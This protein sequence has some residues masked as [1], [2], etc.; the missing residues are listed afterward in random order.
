LADEKPLNGF[1]DKMG[2]NI[3]ALDDAIQDAGPPVE[4][5]KAA[6]KRARVKL[7]RDLVELQNASLATVKSHLLGLH[8]SGASKEPADV[9]ASNPEVMFERDFARCLRPWVESDLKLRCEDCK[10]ERED[11]ESRSLTVKVPSQFPGFPPD[12]ER[13]E[14]HDLCGKCYESRS[15]KKHEREAPQ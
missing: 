6:E 4:S 11:V 13:T 7:L 12:D 5:E 15:S 3:R 2:R 14:S 8:E 9:Y 10:S 1:L